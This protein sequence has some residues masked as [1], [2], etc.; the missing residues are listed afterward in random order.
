V[1][2]DR[3][4]E[5]ASS[6][7]SCC[8]LGLEDVLDMLRRSVWAVTEECSGVGGGVGAGGGCIFEGLVWLLNKDENGCGC[9]MRDGEGRALCGG[10]LVLMGAD[11]YLRCALLPL[12]ACKKDLEERGCEG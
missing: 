8:R 7:V 11:G 4:S 9:C 1:A 3:R 6:M 12:V 2:E 10:M 5:R